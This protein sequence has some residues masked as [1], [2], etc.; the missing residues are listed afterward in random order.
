VQLCNG[1][2]CK[3]E[4]GER[5]DWSRTHAHVK[6][7]RVCKWNQCNSVKST[8]T[9]LHE[10]GHIETTTATM[11]R[12][13]SEYYATKWALEQC[14]LYGIKVPQSIVESYQRYVYRELDRGLRRGGKN[15]PTRDEMKLAWGGVA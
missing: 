10:V 12:C 9:L 5:A 13:E 1:T 15:Y 14:D 7:R 11:R 3:T 6:K 2:I 4:K 8:F